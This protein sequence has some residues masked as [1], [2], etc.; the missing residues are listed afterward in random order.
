MRNGGC[1]RSGLDAD[2]CVATGGGGT[3]GG[4]AGALAGAIGPSEVDR[5][6]VGVVMVGRAV[7]EGV[8]RWERENEVVGQRSVVVHGDKARLGA[9]G[10][11]ELV[12]HRGG[13]CRDEGGGIGTPGEG[14]SDSRPMT[15]GKGLRRRTGRG[16]GR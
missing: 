12:S 3:I 16:C 8:R 15:S 4:P 11:G 5:D 2:V 7:G 10:V 6:S 14:R 1:H 13:G 9:E